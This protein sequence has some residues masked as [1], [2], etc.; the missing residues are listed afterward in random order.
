MSKDDEL[1]PL[2]AYGFEGI[3][4]AIQEDIEED[5]NGIAEI[6]GRS[7]LVLANQHESHLPPTGE[8][9]AEPLQAVAEASSSN[10]RL[11]DD[12]LILH[13]DASLAE[14]SQNGSQAYG[15][16]ERL[17]AMPRTTRMHSELL[18]LPSRPEMPPA[19]NRNSSPAVLTVP[20]LDPI[21]EPSQPSATLRASLDLLQ[22][23]TNLTEPAPRNSAVVSEV[24]LSAGSDGKVLFD[25]PFRSEAGKQY[26]LYSFDEAQTLGSDASSKD[27]GIGSNAASATISQR[28]GRLLLLRDLQQA[29]SMRAIASTSMSRPSAGRTISA[30][31]RLRDILGRQEASGST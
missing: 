8:I 12:V 26:P 31:N 3:L 5:L 25:P 20:P 29:F 19:E 1:P 4:S 7:R 14:G 15:L 24:F 27:Q 18:L 23:R 21:A 13:E 30:E 2:F 22:P 17:Q 6:L 11:A 16:L 9:R 28:I 10:E